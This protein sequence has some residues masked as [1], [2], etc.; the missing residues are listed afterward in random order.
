MVLHKIKLI[1]FIILFGSVLVVYGQSTLTQPDVLSPDKV[2]DAVSVANIMAEEQFSWGLRAFHEGQFNKAFLDFEQALRLNPS[3]ARYGLW[4]GFASYHSGLN[5][6]AIAHWQSVNDAIYGGAWLNNKI[7]TLLF[8]QSPYYDN[9]AVDNW[10]ERGDIRAIEE[11]GGRNVRFLRPTSVKADPLSGGAFVVGY[12]NNSVAKYDVNGRLMQH[13]RG[14]LVDLAGPYDVLP[15]ADGRFFVS[16][17]NGTRISLLSQRGFRL[18]V[19]GNTA[20]QGGLRGP[21]YLANDEQ[22]F[23]YVSDWSTK[24]IVKYNYD[25]QYIMDIGRPMDGFEG[26]QSPSGLAVGLNEIYVADR[27]SNSIFIFDLSGNYLREI[28][29]GELT[30]PEGLTLYKGNYLLVADGPRVVLI[31]LRQNTLTTLTTMDGLAR[32]ITATAFDRN[33]NLMLVDNRR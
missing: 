11:G 17:F 4:A 31:D 18:N 25:G 27:T 9:L 15:L 3:S 32:Q 7:D 22:G 16:E 14:I 8:R 24:R 26:L 19:F 28:G 12:G 20:E 33:N 23:L 30:N 13:Y 10:A 2:P 21:Q 29:R 1:F 6:S 5:S